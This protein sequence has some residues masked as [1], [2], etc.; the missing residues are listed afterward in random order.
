MKKMLLITL[1]VTVTYVLQA[2][3][4]AD[5]GIKGGMNLANLKIENT[6]SP[7]SKIA[8]N[9]GLLAHLHFEP[10]WAIQPEL[11][12]SDQGAKQ[13][14]SGT[15]VKAKLHYINIPV[16][17]QYMAGSGFR[18]ETGPQLGILASAK[19]KTGDSETNSSD[20]YH[21]FDVAWALGASYVTNSGLGIDARYNI[22][23]ANI[24]DAGGSSI[25]NRV[26]Q[27]GLFYQ[28]KVSPD[29]HRHIK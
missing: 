8:I 26:W 21:T 9:A 12:Y 7:D 23:L 18:L 28:F 14:I 4:H 17:L 5:W 27:F 15:E 19:T 2:Q 20:L 6:S 11:M 29:S 25:K 3:V 22:G 1:L 13:D 16:L 10:H 24:N